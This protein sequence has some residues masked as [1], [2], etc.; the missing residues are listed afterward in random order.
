MKSSKIRL[1]STLTLCG[2]ALSLSSIV[3]ADSETDIAGTVGDTTLIAPPT[4]TD[5]TKPQEIPASSSQEDSAASTVTDDNTISS[6]SE[7]SSSQEDSQTSSETQTESK[8]EESET[9]Q[10]DVTT[11]DTPSAPV[12]VPTIDGETTTIIPD[13]SVPTNNPKVTADTAKQTGASQVGTTSTVTGQVVRD[14]TTTNPVQLAN[15]AIITDI[16]DGMVTLAT[17]EKINPETVGVIQN[18]DGTYTAKTIQGEMVTLPH[19]GEKNTF[20]LVI[21]GCFI[22]LGSVAIRFKDR[23]KVFINRV[24]L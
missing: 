24:K 4:S 18:S 21:A 8:S 13:L 6:S 1:L 14:V 17:G 11:D 15:G 7:Q 19:T 20:M 10:E 3:F 5:G 23:L 22:L 9:P 16:R 12:E 2:L